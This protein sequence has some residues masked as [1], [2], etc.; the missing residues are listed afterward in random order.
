MAGTGQG[1]EGDVKIPAATVIATEGVTT[2]W[3]TA[4]RHD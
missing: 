2:K 1:D 4:K 3:P